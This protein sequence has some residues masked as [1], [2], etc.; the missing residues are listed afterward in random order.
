[1]SYSLDSGSD[2][3]TVNSQ[4]MDVQ[5][6]SGAGAHTL[7]VKAF[8]QQGA[9][10]VT[11]VAVTVAA[12]SADSADTAD[13]AASANS[14][15]SAPSGAV[16]VSS[17]QALK[18][19][20]A[21]HDY[22]TNGF[23]SGKTS[24]V[25]SPAHSGTTRETTTVFKSRSGERY[26]VSFADNRTSTNFLYDVWVYIKSPSTDIANIEMDL[27]QTMPDGDTV[28]FGIE[29]SGTSGTWDVTENLASAKNFKGNWKRTGVACNP[30]NWS[31][32]TWHHIQA[33]YSR[34]DTG[35]VTYHA[36]YLDGVKHALNSTVFNARALGWGNS[37]STNFQIDGIS[38]GTATVY[39]DDLKISRW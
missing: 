17:I 11:D 32:G 33:T 21:G 8:G 38:S 39:F 16:T 10:C 23:S 24:L 7:H 36:V 3:A 29:C 22:G 13:A 37:L 14:V 15:I 12:P 9:A 4:S 25:G 1:M 27:N 26:S 6:T 20:K 19:W 18:S 28:I 31:T 35:Y 2:L 5:V 30:R 34:N